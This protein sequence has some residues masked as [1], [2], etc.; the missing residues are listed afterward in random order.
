[1]IALNR[2]I[3]DAISDELAAYVYS[4]RVVDAAAFFCVCVVYRSGTPLWDFHATN[5]KHFILSFIHC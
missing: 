2:S 5:K 3:Y 4:P 1:M